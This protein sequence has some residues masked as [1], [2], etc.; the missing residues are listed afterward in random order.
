VAEAMIEI[1]DRATRNVVGPFENE[2]TALDYIER[3]LRHRLGTLVVYTELEDGSI[4]VVLEA[5]DVVRRLGDQPPR[6]MTRKAMS[7]ALRAEGLHVAESSP[8]Y[9][10]DMAAASVRSKAIFEVKRSASR[11]AACRACRAPRS[12]HVVVAHESGGWHVSGLSKTF[13]TKKEAI[14][15]ARDR[16]SHSGGQL[17]VRGRDGKTRDTKVAGA[18]I[19]EPGSAPRAPRKPKSR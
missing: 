7:K 13:E 1:Y 9:P 8:P 3:R 6:V 15:A 11:S 19:R 10:S 12:P 17:T 14:S 18:E 16:L 4:D 5:E 2:R